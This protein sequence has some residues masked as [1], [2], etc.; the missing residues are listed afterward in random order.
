M[1]SII[2]KQKI[3]WKRKGK[4][5]PEAGIEHATF[6]LQMKTIRALTL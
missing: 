5:V 4:K 2:K 3:G 1:K 6:R